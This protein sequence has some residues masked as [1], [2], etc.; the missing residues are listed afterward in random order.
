MCVVLMF[1]R[2][3]DQR[4]EKLPFFVF[5]DFNFRLDSKKVI[6]VSRVCFLDIL[7]MDGYLY[8]LSG[9]YGDVMAQQR[10]NDQLYTRAVT[11]YQIHSD[12]ALCHKAFVCDCVCE[13][14][15]SI[16]KVVLEPHCLFRVMTH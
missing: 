3:T 4:Y 2:I 11:C 7:V 13:G 14:D 16:V 15:R 1:C 12:T 9:C 10:A 6:E 5:G 8:T